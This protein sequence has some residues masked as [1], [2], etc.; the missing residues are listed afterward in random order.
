MEDIQKREFEFE[1]PE[2]LSTIEGSKDIINNILEQHKTFVEGGYKDYI[3]PD[4]IDEVITARQEAAA[5]EAEATKAREEKLKALSAGI[6]PEANLE[7]ALSKVQI[8]EG[9]DDATIT[10]KLKQVVEKF[11]ILAAVGTPG[12][13]KKI[14]VTPPE[15][16]ETK[17]K[18]R[19]F[20]RNE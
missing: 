1:V 8:E 9:D 4:K 2:S 12:V 16:K 5:K 17:K 20:M 7:L 15:P 3:A 18:K 10:A 14:I 6:L 13:T 19:F 11:P